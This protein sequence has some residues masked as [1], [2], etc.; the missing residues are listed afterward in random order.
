MRR[1]LGRWCALLCV[2]ALCFAPASAWAEFSPLL[3][4]LTQGKGIHADVSGSLDAL[5]PLT[6]QSLT[7]VNSWLSRLRVSLDVGNGGDSAALSMDGDP[8]FSVRIDRTQAGTLTAF[9]PSGGAYWTDADGKDALRLLS[10]GEDWLIPSPTLLPAF[11]LNLAQQ[12]YPLLAEAVTPRTVQDSTSVKNALSSQS[13][14]NYVFKDGELN[15][16][17]PQVLEILLPLLRETL[18]DQPA[19][20]AAAERYLTTATFSGECRF[21]RLLDKSGGDMGLQFTGQMEAEGLDKRKIT[22]FGGF[23]PDRGGYVSLSLPAVKGKNTLKITF[24]AKLTVNGSVNTLT[25]DGSFTRT[26]NGASVSAE[27]EGS[28]KNTVKNGGEQWSGKV[29]ATIQDSGGKTVWTISPA[30]TGANDT[31][32]GTVTVQKKVGSAVKLKGTVRL[33]LSPTA[34]PPALS[35]ENAA[36]LRGL[37]EAAA[38]AQVLQEMTPL[39]RVFLRLMAALPDDER[40]LLTHDLRTDAWMNGPSAPA[41]DPEPDEEPWDTWIVVE[42]E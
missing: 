7:A 16:I 19:W 25:F 8:L 40:I 13:Y 36:N 14:V 29:T 32:S 41:A 11:Y 12:L 5:D 22:L 27:M 1:L 39:S 20:Y 18:T 42:E 21:K 15:E 9:S 6:A 3:T 4:S 26:L 35:A 30:L 34:E 2:L 17:W 23:T 38:R 31:L 33:S 24:G 37:D 28:L 10:G